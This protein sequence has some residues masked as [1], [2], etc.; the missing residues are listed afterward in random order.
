[1]ALTFTGTD[2]VNLGTGVTANDTSFTYY[3]WVFIPD[4]SARG[5]FFA[6]GATAGTSHI[7]Q[8]PSGGGELNYFRGR[9]T[10]SMDYLSNSTPFGTDNKWYFV[11]LMVDTA[12][13]ANQQCNLYVGDLTTLATEVTYT[14]TGDGSGAFGDN[15]AVAETLANRLSPS[16]NRAFPGDIAVAAHVNDAL[17]LSQIQSLQFNPRV[18]PN[19]DYF[20]HFGFNGTGTQADWSGNGNS[21]T[22]TGATVADHVPLPPPFGFDSPYSSFAAG[23]PVTI[24]PLVIHHMKQQGMA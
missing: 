19:T 13:A 10:T 3:F 6:R 7:M 18:V 5:A 2:I 16:S 9:A 8:V 17:S 11:A 15:S 20:F 12:L 23:A 1:M 21:G 14:K 4:T 24:I 22:V